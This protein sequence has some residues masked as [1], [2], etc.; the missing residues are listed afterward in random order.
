[1]TD[2]ELIVELNKDREDNQ[3]V[4]RACVL[5]LRALAGEYGRDGQIAAQLIDVVQDLLEI[6]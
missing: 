1:M 2:K 6:P 5:R 4:D 3:A